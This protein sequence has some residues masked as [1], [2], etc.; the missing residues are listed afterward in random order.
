M[1]C[2]ICEHFCCENVLHFREKISMHLS[3][4]GKN[5]A[6]KYICQKLCAIIRVF[7]GI[8]QIMHPEPNYAISHLCIILE[9]LL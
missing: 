2:D 6:F 1:I 7:L 5:I 3:R 9:A 8:M 4:Y